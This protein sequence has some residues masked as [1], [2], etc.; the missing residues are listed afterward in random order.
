MRKLTA[1]LTGLL[2]LALPGAAQADHTEQ[3][4]FDII[5]DTPGD[6]RVVVN[7]PYLR[8]LSHDVPTAGWVDGERAAYRCAYT[9]VI[10]DTAFAEDPEGQELLGR[11]TFT[12]IEGAEYARVLD[13]YMREGWRHHDGTLDPN[14]GEVRQEFAEECPRDSTTYTS[15]EGDP[16]PRPIIEMQDETGQILDV[17][18]YV[19]AITDVGHDFRI[20]S[21]TPERITVVGYQDAFPVVA[22]YY[23][24][25]NGGR[26]VCTQGCIEEPSPEPS[27]SPSPDPTPSPDPSP[28]PEPLTADFD[29]DGD[30]DFDDLRAFI[31]ALIQQF[32]G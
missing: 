25:M 22:V 29:G 2:V 10:R 21:Q 31:D 8:H 3:D 11:V 13:R 7:A 27:P 15:L 30:V 18:S 28:S 24:P 17:R 23:E 4:R 26:V 5:V 6:D 16:G 12:R 20:V 9:F 14:R 32:T 19:N 1:V